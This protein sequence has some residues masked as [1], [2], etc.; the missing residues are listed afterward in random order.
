MFNE[1]LLMGIEKVL[2]LDYVQRVYL[3]YLFYVLI[4]SNMINRQRSELI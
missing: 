4:I 3:I 1:C 2:E